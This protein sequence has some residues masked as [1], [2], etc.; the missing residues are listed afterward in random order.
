MT[1]P[2][3]DA[4]LANRYRKFLDAIERQGSVPERVLL[5]CRNRIRQIHG[6]D[7]DGLSEQEAMNLQQQ[8]L[9]D[10]TEQERLALT[11]AELMPFDHHAVE[12]DQVE[13]ARQA[14]GNAG[15]VSLLTALAF[16]DVNC[17]FELSLGEA[18]P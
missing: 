12:D 5:L 9:T 2:A 17:R 15:G 3:L 14:F 4:D 10:F 6:L 8:R 11:L 13:A 7:V 18:L 1:L 16:Y